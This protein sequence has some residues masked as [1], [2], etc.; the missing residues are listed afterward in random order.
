[1]QRFACLKKWK[2]RFLNAFH[3]YK[4]KEQ[5]FGVLFI[6]IKWNST[7]LKSFSSPKIRYTFRSVIILTN[8]KI[9]FWSDF[10]V[11]NEQERTCFTKRK[12]TFSKNVYFEKTKWKN[13]FLKVFSLTKW[14]NTCSKRFRFDKLKTRFWSAFHVAK[15][16]IHVFEQIFMYQ[17]KKHVFEAISFWQLKTR[18]WSAFHFCKKLKLFFSEA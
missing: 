3:F 8:S 6:F 16:L 14:K 13:M 9:R 4:L 5:L 12:C 17:N 2:T 1:M 18:L 10:H 7:F 11:T 15:I